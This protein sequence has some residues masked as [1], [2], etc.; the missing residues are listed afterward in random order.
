MQK[1]FIVLP[2]LACFLFLS[3]LASAQISELKLINNSPCP[4]TVQVTNNDANC[5][6]YCSSALTTVAA[7]TTVSIPLNCLTEEK[8]GSVQVDIM[9][10][11][12]GVRIGTGCGLP[13]FDTYLDCGSQARTAAMIGSGV[14]I[15][16]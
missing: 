4:V 14:A 10:N 15:I 1:R 8:G 11:Q 16:N 9:D 6:A 12:S 2:L 5:N 13:G 7:N 3:N